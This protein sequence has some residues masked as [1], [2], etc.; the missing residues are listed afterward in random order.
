MNK[1]LKSGERGPLAAWIHDHHKTLLVSAV[2]IVALVV[3]WLIPSPITHYLNPEDEYIAEETDYTEQTDTV[4]MVLPDGSVYDGDLIEGTTTRQGYGRLVRKD[5]RAYEG[6]WH[7]DHLMFG[8]CTSQAGVYEGTFDKDLRYNGYGI[9]RYA[10]PWF[11]PKG[12]AA[13]DSSHLVK[14]YTGNWRHGLKQGLGRTTYATGA[15]EFGHYQDDVFKPVKGQRFSVGDRVYGL[16]VSHHQGVIDWSN[17]ALYCNDRGVANTGRLKRSKYLQPVF[18]VYVKAT[19]GA[20]YVDPTYS[21]RV[22]EAAHHGYVKGAYHFMR[23]GSDVNEQIRNFCSTA[24]WQ[25]GDMPPALDIEVENEMR[26]FGLEHTLKW[27]YTWLEGVERQMGVRPIIYTGELIRDRY[28]K[29]DP[30]FSKYQCWIARYRE[31]GPANKVWRIW[32]YTEKGR[33]MGYR[34]TVDG[35]LFKGGYPGFV[36]YLNRQQIR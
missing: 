22:L 23:L 12:L 13:A 16:D 1:A 15:M 11:D 3:V 29:K 30:R 9:M 20:T 33:V 6:E 25:P 34:G 17:L 36:D 4:G 10:T 18:F 32:Q 14:Q 19:E 31:A 27:V 28:L 21:M 26:A 24:T 2:M 5:G 8:T 7:H 35:N